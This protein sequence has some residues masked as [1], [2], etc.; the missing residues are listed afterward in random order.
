V[1]RPY[2]SMNFHYGEIRCMNT[3]SLFFFFGALL[4]HVSG[5]SVTA[6][7]RKAIR[8]HGLR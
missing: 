6:P 7:W 3:G 4:Q 5:S 2:E 8:V 1:D